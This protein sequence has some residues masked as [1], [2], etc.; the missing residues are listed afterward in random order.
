M[1]KAFQREPL[2]VWRLTIQKSNSG[3]RGSPNFGVVWK[4]DDQGILAGLWPP[5]QVPSVRTPLLVTDTETFW[6]P[7]PWFV[8][9]L[10][11]T[12]A[13]FVLALCWLLSKLFQG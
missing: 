8:V 12:S 6:Q 4:L 7:E 11:V 2:N 13:L 3:V 5:F 9:V 1:G 10:T